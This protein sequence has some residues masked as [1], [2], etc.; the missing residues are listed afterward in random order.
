[1]IFYDIFKKFM[2]F[3]ITL[4]FYDI[5]HTFMIFMICGRPD[6]IAVGN[7]LV[8]SDVG[9]EKRTLGN[10]QYFVFLVHGFSCVILIFG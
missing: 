10:I 2:I 7:I 5:F 3:M 8:S 4:N 6:V 9:V 1:M